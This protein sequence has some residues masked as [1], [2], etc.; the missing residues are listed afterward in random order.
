MNRR[1]HC[2]SQ[3]RGLPGAPLRDF[4]STTDKQLPVLERLPTL[5]FARQ[6]QRLPREAGH[7]F[8][9]GSN[10]SSAGRRALSLIPQWELLLTFFRQLPSTSIDH[11]R[12][13]DTNLSLFWNQPS[14]SIAFLT[15]LS[16]L[17]SS[18]LG[19]RTCRGDLGEVSASKRCC[20]G[21]IA[22]RMCDRLVTF[23]ALP[24]EA[25]CPAARPRVC[26]QVASTCS[27]RWR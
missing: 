18:A 17:R 5:T 21:E 16:G 10:C 6:V 2:L 15:Q 24:V 9:I 26:C 25:R 19:N 3:D 14:D 13:R 20:R 1:G 11:F 8:A 12:S 27:R 7:T 4:R 22:S 23:R